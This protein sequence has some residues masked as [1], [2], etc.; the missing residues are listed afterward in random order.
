M[1]SLKGL[2]LHDGFRQLLWAS[3]DWDLGDETDLVKD[4]IA[5][6][7]TDPAEFPGVVRIDADRALYS[8]AVRGEQVDCSASSRSDAPVGRAG[9][10]ARPLSYVRQIVQPALECLRRELRCARKLGSRERDLGVRE[11]DLS[12][13]LEMS[14]NQ[15]R[16]R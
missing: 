1:P 2:V 10:E 6:A 5:N 7:I 4:T 9:T 8:F 3:D 12:L 13:M 14:S 15:I 16:D 11:R